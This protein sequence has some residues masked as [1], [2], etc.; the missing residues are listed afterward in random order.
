MGDVHLVGGHNSSI[1]NPKGKRMGRLRMS[2]MGDVSRLSGCESP[3]TLKRDGPSP[4]RRTSPKGYLLTYGMQDCIALGMPGYGKQ[5]SLMEPGRSFWK[6]RRS[7]DFKPLSTPPCTS[8]RW[9]STK[10]RWR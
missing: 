4:S 1:E 8:V 3:V 10:S 2:G 7:V 5:L 9:H 6:S